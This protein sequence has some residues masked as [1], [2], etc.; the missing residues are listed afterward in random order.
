MNPDPSLVARELLRALRGRRSQPAWSRRLGYRSNVAWLWEAGRRSPDAAELLRAARLAGVDVDAAITVFLGRPPAWLGVVPDAEVPGALLRDLRGTA[1]L[2]ELARRT[3]HT[4]FVWARWL[5]GTT[6]PRLPD[7]LAAIDAAS[8]RLVD[9]VAAFVVPTRI[10]S[11]AEAWSRLEARRRGAALHPWTQAIL[12]VLELDAYRAAP[13][14]GPGWIAARL[15]IPVEE[16]QRCLS[17]LVQTGQVA[18]VEGRYVQ[19]DTLP[20]DTR[21]HPEVG[22]ALKQH[23]SAV[24][25]DRIEAGA[26]GQFSYNVFTVSETDLERLRELHLRY[27]HEL[28]AIVAASQPGERVAVANVQLFALDDPG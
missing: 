22:R 11:I 17:F 1:S 26:P 23:W 20:V 15:G 28:R 19:Q 27:F 10:P 6:R 5:A 7:F 24:A 2:V 3:G 18:R 25:R 4:R 8:L 9:F 21:R 12:R 13:D 16:E 14:P